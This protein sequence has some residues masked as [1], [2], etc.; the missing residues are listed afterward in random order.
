[1]EHQQARKSLSVT[2]L[3]LKFP[4]E[5]TLIFK[6]LSFSV[7]PGEKVLLLGPSGCGKSTLLQ[8]LSGIIP[9]SIEVPLKYDAIQLPESWGFVF[10]DPDTQFC[11]P[12]VDEELAFV[13][14]NIQVPRSEMDRRIEKAL[15]MV[16]LQGIPIHTQIH[17]LSQGMKQRLALASVLLLQPEVLF[18]DEP[19]ALLDP[20]GVE[21]IWTSVKEVAAEKTVLIVEHKIDQ[22]ADWVDR[23]V[24]FKDNGE[25]LAD[26]RPADVFR[27]YKQQLIQ[28]GIW[29]PKVWEDYLV[30]P[31]YLNLKKARGDECLSTH[32]VLL[33]EK[34]NGYRGE[35]A[36]IQISHAE[37]VPG[38]WIGIIGENGA[39]KSTFLLAL[40]QLLRTTGQY[41]LE[42]NTIQWKK[43]KNPLPKG[44]SLVFQNP[45]LQFIT[46]S[47][48]DELSFSG[49][50]KGLDEEMLQI[51]VKKWIERFQLPLN[52]NRHPFQLSLGQK[53]RLSVATAFMSGGK[54]LL[55][56]EPTFGQDARNTF[57]ILEQ[58]EELRRGGTTI[59]MVTHDE[60]I[61]EHFMTEVWKIDQGILVD[62]S[63]RNPPEFRRKE[64]VYAGTVYSS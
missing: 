29:Y 23:V 21:Q 58:L 31:A 35:K 49:R 22:I 64:Q 15:E 28:Y 7:V 56:D 62:V 14:E 63:K 52:E 59:M 54:I 13:L 47:V 20:D 60:Q 55:L 48:V 3:R 42:E 33:L 40:M 16:G 57:M 44:L 32:P 6:D 19:S 17:D 30:S 2:N 61:V 11:M 36:K 50:L 41:V 53:R 10:Q 26:G 24:L 45:E 38:S 43:R 34:F 39:G 8:V 25:I 18:L 46:N 9:K 27:F 1:M 4:N 5:P 37:V 51:K 12:Y